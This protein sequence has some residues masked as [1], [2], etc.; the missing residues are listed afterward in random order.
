[1]EK[2]MTRNIH[3]KL[4]HQCDEQ[5][6]QKSITIPAFIHLPYLMLSPTTASNNTAISH[7]QLHSAEQSTSYDLW[8]FLFLIRRLL[9]T[10]G[11]HSKPGAL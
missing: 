4:F 1:M 7:A 5:P 11:Q 2:F 9:S 6:T 8:G 3:E 10:Q